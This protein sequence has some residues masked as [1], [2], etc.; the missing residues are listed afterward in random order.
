VCDSIVY[1]D[2]SRYDDVGAATWFIATSINGRPPAPALDSPTRAGR[3]IMPDELIGNA[4]TSH[5]RALNYCSLIICRASTG[6]TG[7]RREG[8][9]R[10]RAVY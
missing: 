6:P 1:I 4:Q 2:L 9:T 10:A 3:R 7:S 8:K 5:E